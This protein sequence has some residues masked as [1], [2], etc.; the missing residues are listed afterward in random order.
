MKIQT[1]NIYDYARTDDVSTYYYN[2]TADKF[3]S[4]MEFLELNG[5]VDAIIVDAT[6]TSQ[7]TDNIFSFLYQTE[8][9]TDQVWMRF[10]KE[11][12]V[13]N[14]DLILDPAKPAYMIQVK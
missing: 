8:P 2:P 1:P 3:V 9:N 5:D 7:E 14:A 10:A 4:K 11:F 6:N 12:E 13:T